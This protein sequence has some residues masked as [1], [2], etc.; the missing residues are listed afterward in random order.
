M[1]EGSA[2]VLRHLCVGMI[3]IKEVRRIFIIIN[4]GAQTVCYGAIRAFVCVTKLQC[5]LQN[6]PFSNSEYWCW[7]L[8]CI[9]RRETAHL[10]NWPL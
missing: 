3:K 6:A 1:N 5:R 9:G 8:F 10:N 2:G 4:L 7:G